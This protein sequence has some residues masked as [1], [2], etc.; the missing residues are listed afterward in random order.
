M[1]KRTSRI[2]SLLL[3][4]TM[5]LGLLAGCSKSSGGS[6]SGS[7]DKDTITVAT[8][9]ET[10]SLGPYDHNATA[11]WL[12]NLLTYTSLLRLDDNLNPV[13]DLAESYE[14]VSDTCWEFKLRQDVKFHDG[15]QMTAA[16][17]KAS[18]EYAKTFAE[19]S[20]FNDSIESVDVV[21]DYTVRINTKTP[22]ASLL[23]NLTQHANA[24]VP[25]ALIDSG[26]DFNTNPIGTGPYVWKEWKRGDQLEFEAFADYYLGE[27][28]IKNVIWKIIPEGSS[29]TIALEAGEVDMVVDVESMDVDRIKENPDLATV[30]Y[31]PTNVTWLMLNNEKPGLDNQNFR[32]A[33]NSAIDKESVVTVALNNLGSVCETQ[34]PNNLPGTSDANTD[35]YDLEKAKAYLEES[36]V[37]VSGMSFPIICSDDTKKRAGEVIQ[38]NL[39]EIG[40]EANIES[41]DLATY[42]STV[43]EGNFVAAIGGYGMGDT[44]SYL[45]GVY[46]SKSI[47]ASNKS[48]LNDP[49]IDALIDQATATMDQAERE[50]LTEQICAK[51]NEI[52]TQVPLYQPISMRAYNADLKNVVITAAGDCRIED[53]SWN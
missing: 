49:E 31:T 40:I 22:D 35:T 29:R 19:V 6:G 46:H 39:K 23:F 8:M 43:A 3:L 15:T 1:K 37:D 42:L 28:A 27:P 13:P 50:A 25:K 41:M 32:H 5:A 9:A 20:L 18:L 51:L 33:I 14:A 16:D 2:L 12:V 53:I 7:A 52:C 17:V 44:I 38:A 48:R 36:G 45:N 4:C 34:V 30:E 24:I 21:D 10:P 47:N 11:G 26:N